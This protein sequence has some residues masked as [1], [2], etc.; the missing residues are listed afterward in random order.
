LAT[1]SLA[2]KAKHGGVSIYTTGLKVGLGKSMHNYPDEFYQAKL[3]FAAQ[4]GV[5]GRLRLTK[6]LVI[7]PEV[8]YETIGSKTALGNMRTH[9]VITPCNLLFDLLRKNTLDNHIF[10][11]FGGYYS[12]SF[13]GRID[14][15]KIDF[16]NQ[17][18]SN[19]YGLNYGISFEVVG[20]QVGFLA[21]QGLTNI[22]KQG[23]DGDIRN[24]ALYMTLGFR[25]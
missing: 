17:Y 10:L 20:I 22:L 16:N 11:V 6:R 24:T 13:A 8:Q 18:N 25:F 12:H 15:K 21:K 5:Y 23:A 7:Q 2:R 19:D 4:V 9:A 1:A 3:L 14:G